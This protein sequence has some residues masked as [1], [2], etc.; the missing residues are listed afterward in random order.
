MNERLSR[1]YRRL[2][3]AYPGPYRRRHGAEILTTLLDAA[4]PGRGRPTM[5]EVRD[6]VGGGLR[7]RFRLPVGRLMLLTAVLGALTVGGLGAAAGSAAGWATAAT[8]TDAAVGDLLDRAA[9][10]PLEHYATRQPG[11]LGLR[12]QIIVS[13]VGPTTG[14]L[15]AV[16]GRL[17]AA[18]WQVEPTPVDPAS[19]G[20]PDHRTDLIA[21]GH[22]P[23]LL[24][25]AADWGGQTSVSVVASPSTPPLVVP[26][27]VAGALLGLLAGWLLAGRVGYR[28]RR[29]PP[30]Q[31]MFV[32]GLAGGAI[33]LLGRSTLGAWFAGY[34][35]AT[36]GAAEHTGID[37]LPGPDAYATYFY[38]TAPDLAVLAGLGF[39]VLAFMAVVVIEIREIKIRE[40][41]ATLP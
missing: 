5:T 41:V 35:A 26:L 13:G 14:A 28:V 22:G 9:G 40:K 3:L 24:V 38:D 10:E 36:S 25:W 11:P 19:G 29:S 31:R 34:R 21:E 37:R 30:W 33:L 12:S 32:G 4:G 8:P 20:R 15:D 17:E 7:Q 18:G 39:A 1:Q 6:V 2:L 27:T 16:R 23:V